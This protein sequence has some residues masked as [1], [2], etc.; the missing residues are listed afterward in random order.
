MCKV[1][2][3]KIICDGSLGGHSAVMFEPYSDAADMRG[4]LVW[5][6]DELEK[7][8]G[9]A[10]SRA[11]Q[12]AV[13]CIGDRMAHIVL[14]TLARAMN[15][16]PRRDHRHR[17]EH[18]SVMPPRLVRR[19]KEL[20]LIM[21]VQPPFIYSEKEWLGKRLG[22]RVNYTYPF[23]SMLESGLMLCAGSD[24]PVEPADPILG[25]YSS[26]NR[27]GVAPAEAIG[28]EDAI[29]MYTVNAAYASFEE[30]IKG[31]IE[32]GKLADLVAL[33]DDPLAIPPERLRDISVEMTMVGGTIIY[34]E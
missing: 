9:E 10:H 16:A 18:A 27:L 26:V 25:I 20:G 22:E 11:I 4:I 19:A 23:R 28:V 34:S 2:P 29:R 15:G 3:W 7:M 31:T 30:N 32:P 17:L 24:A 33:S 6:E 21:S 5:S 12:L 8:I 14:D 1:G 13:H